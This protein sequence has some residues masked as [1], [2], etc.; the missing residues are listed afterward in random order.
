MAKLFV[1]TKPARLTTSINSTT[2]T[3]TV[4]KIEDREG[5]TLTLADFGDTGYGVFEPG[6]DNEEHFNFSAI[7]SQT[8]TITRDVSMKSPYTASGT[9]KAHAAGSRVVLY[10]NT[11]AFYADVF[12]SKNNTATIDA[13]HTYANTA[14]PKLDSYVAPTDNAEFASKKYVDDTAGGTPISQNRIVPAATAGA[15]ITAGNL[16][17]LDT[18][19]NEWLLCDADTATTVEQVLLGIAQGA[20]TDGNAITG[21]V[22]LSGLDSNQ[23]G[24]T[25][26]DLMYASNTAGAIASSTG[27]NTRVIGQAYSS[28]ELY[29]DP[30]FFHTVK[31]ASKDLLESITASASEINQLDG[32]TITA[33]QLTEAGTFFANTDMTGAEAE[34]LTDGSDADSLHV[35]LGG[36]IGFDDNDNTFT[37]VTDP[38]QHATV[39][40][41]AF[42]TTTYGGGLYFFE[43]S[44]NAWTSS[45]Y[46]HPIIGS[47]NTPPLWSTID[48][49]TIQFAARVI[50][51]SGD[52]F[53]GLGESSA[54]SG[55]YTSTARKVGF[56]T[57]G[58]TLYATTA[59][60]T[61]AD[62]SDIS[63]GITVTNW[64]FYK[65]VFNPGTDA[66]FYVNGTLKATLTSN[67]PS[68]ANSFFLGFGGE[69]NTE[70]FQLSPM[71]ITQKLV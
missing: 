37:Y 61:T 21:G 17:Y 32:A 50:G 56:A 52:K 28:T 39:A 60:G 48:D 35:H 14:I 15:T 49:V 2:T 59:D 42:N 41:G 57:D 18:T 33:S 3:C 58:G 43:S 51:T 25:A 23:S 9:G 34:T 40:N 62:T 31:E 7:S 45:Q 8:L 53:W 27:T 44:G 5:N 20:G 30:Y 54:Q 47:A 38:A 36:K 46:I 1:S 64:N 71:V 16:V 67:L 63:S 26:G 6:T 68:D 66:K 10:S 13:V 65:I 69:T 70:D 22:L 19:A 11:P 12:V 24:M 29:F 4:D 55:A